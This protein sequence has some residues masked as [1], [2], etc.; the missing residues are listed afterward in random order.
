[1]SNTDPF[2]SF[3][4]NSVAFEMSPDRL[5]GIYDRLAE[6]ALR[7]GTGRYLFGLMTPKGEIPAE[8]LKDIDIS[9]AQRLF[10]PDD[11]SVFVT[12]ATLSHQPLFLSEPSDETSEKLGYISV[13]VKSVLGATALYGMHEHF[14]VTNSDGRFNADVTTEYLSM[15]TRHPIARGEQINLTECTDEEFIKALLNIRAADFY[16]SFMPEDLKAVEALPDALT[17]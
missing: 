1:M 14:T 5:N 2:E 9:L 4:D 11:E 8:Y 10:H 13:T 6:I 17:A 3:H 15:D 12:E 16:R 7:D